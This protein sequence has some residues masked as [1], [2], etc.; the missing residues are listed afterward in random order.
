ML[1]EPEEKLEEIEFAKLHRQCSLFRKLTIGFGSL[2]V[3]APAFGLI[4]TVLG[5]I[6]AFDKMGHEGGSDPTE[7][8]GNVS[9]ALIATATGLTVSLPSIILCVAFLIAY[10]KRKHRLALYTPPPP[11]R[12]GRV[13][14]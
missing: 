2:A 5:M 12:Q 11:T 7:L 14:E 6:R 10:L 9:H 1:S 3:V 4:E 8:A 13:D